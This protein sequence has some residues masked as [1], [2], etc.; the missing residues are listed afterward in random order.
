LT[1]PWLPAQRRSGRRDTIL[2]A[3]I[4]ETAD[5]VM[6]LDWPRADFRIAS[7]EFLIGLLAT[8]CPPAGN[9]A[10]RQGWEQPPDPATLNAAFAP[11]AHAF[12]LDGDGPRFLQD[13]EDLVSDAE[14]IERLLIEAPGASTQSRNTDLLVRRG[15]VASLGRAGA[16]MALF[17]FQSWAPA[18]GAG[19]RTGLRGGGPMTTLVMPGDRPT[20]WRQLWANVPLGQVPEPAELKRIFPWLAPT[21][22]SEGSNVVTPENAHP[23]QCWWGM[24][25]RIRLD[26][27]ILEAPRACDLTGEADSVQVVSWRQRPR[28]ANYVGWGKIHPLTPHYALKDGGEFLPLHPQPGGIGYRHWLGLVLQTQDGLRL[29]AKSIST[30]RS[31]REMDAR[32]GRTRLLAAGFAMDNM[33]A[34]AFVESEMPLPAAP[35]E[36]RRQQQDALAAMLVLSANQ[37]AG[38][39]RQA[40]R[41][42]L[43]SAGATVKLDAELFSSLRESLWEQTE[44]D[45]A[46]L[47]ERAPADA[48]QQ[49]LKRLHDLALALFD[50]AAPLTPEN[51]GAAPRI[52]KA[53]RNLLFALMGYGKEG[54]TLF[55]T[56]GLAVAPAKTKKKAKAA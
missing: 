18:G 55:T 56:L 53:R 42:A 16:A 33:K 46:S 41:L 50:E 48:A 26:F 3:Q 2:P 38:W 19:N 45:F 24:P 29:P 6:A 1:D 52:G 7:L 5:A 25:R 8:A 28:G 13:H 11:L 9:R 39:L 49:W 17:T 44:A 47:L 15:R 27:T 21:V 54:G 36:A 22:T 14:A 51:G 23:L 43:F 4:G 34:R 10:W 40:V 30:W 37:V 12:N 32:S 35:D 20:L 31:D